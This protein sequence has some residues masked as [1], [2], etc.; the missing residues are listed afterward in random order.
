MNESLQAVLQD[1]QAELDPQFNTLRA[2]T[3]ALKGAVNLAAEEKLDAL[4]MQKQLAKLQLTVEQLPDPAFA[5]AVEAFAA[6]TQAALD[7]L[8]FDFA[9]DLRDVFEA[10]GHTVEGRPPTLVVGDL[11]LQI[12][13]ALRK[14]QWRYGK[15]ALTRLIPL[16]IPN[17][18]K[19]FEAQHKAIVE[20]PLAAE[21]FFAELHT[22]WEQLLAQRLQRPPGGRVNLV[23][24]Y[25]KVTI[26]RQNAR[27]WNAPSR[28]TFRD[29]ERAH[30]VRDLVLAIDA[31]PV[32][33]NDRVLKFSLAG[34]SKAQAESAARSVWI[35]KSALD[36]EYY[37][38]LTFDR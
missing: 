29:Y 2:A 15:E 37:G 12:E 31:Q 13:I 24:L 38:S 17:L 6:Q 27:F 35:P 19:A 11:V 21:A 36:G 5:A 22:A 18:L 10:R 33:V 3:G 20:R 14:A 1:A 16:S 9:R 32:T 30:F 34:A 4:A 26:N 25:S 8:A 23:E 28:S 7:G